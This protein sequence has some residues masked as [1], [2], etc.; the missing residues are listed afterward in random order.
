MNDDSH[1]WLDIAKALRNI[2]APSMTR[3]QLAL[4]A[5]DFVDL[6]TA[7]TD[8]PGYL[9]DQFIQWLRLREWSDDER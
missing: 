7:A 8:D 3:D 9:V 1:Y 6:A 2:Y 4:S 5:Q